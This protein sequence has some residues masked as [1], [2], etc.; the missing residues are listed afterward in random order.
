VQSLFAL[1]SF[2]CGEAEI[3]SAVVDISRIASNTAEQVSLLAEDKRI[4]LKC[5]APEPV[6]ARGDPAR[7]K[8][9][10]VN[11]LDNAIKYTPDGGTIQVSVRRDGD[12]PVLEVTDNGIGIPQ[13]A[14]SR[15]F[16]RFYRV[17]RGR[18]RDLGGAG[19]GLSIV[20]AIC[21]AHQANATVE[22]TVGI[23]S[24]F[25]VV[26][27]PLRSDSTPRSAID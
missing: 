16:E 18:S 15:V 27:P 4:A 23:G 7:I 17:D 10:V 20:K 22:S 19:L 6:F 14:T 12:Q 8:Q 1:A 2:D 26:F 3:E 11:L 5:N 21:V 24:T 25:R 9:V 13:N